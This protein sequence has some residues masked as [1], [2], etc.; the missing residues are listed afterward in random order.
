[1]SLS[2]MHMIIGE[3]AQMPVPK[4][5]YTNFDSQIMAKH[6]VVVVNWLLKQFSSPSDIG[7]MTEL[8]VLYNAWKTGTATFRQLTLVEWEDWEATCFN[9]CM[10]ELQQVDGGL[11][12]QLQ[13]NNSTVQS[14]TAEPCPPS[15]SFQSP[16]P[17]PT[18]SLQLDGHGA[19]LTFA[20]FRISLT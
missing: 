10:A 8:R 2:D 17:M 20:S 14:T 4:M 1:M 15:E 11:G 19:Q 16:L 12:S 7:S 5:F 13:M 9:T 3:T 6:D 18:T